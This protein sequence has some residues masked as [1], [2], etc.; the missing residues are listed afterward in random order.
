MS[1]LLASAV[2]F[3]LAAEDGAKKVFSDG[4][5][6]AEWAW[7]IPVVPMVAAF[8]IVLFGK[9]SP[10]KGWGMAWGILT[11]LFG[12]FAI[13]S[14]LTAFS[15]K[16]SVMPAPFLVRAQREAGLPAPGLCDRSDARRARRRAE[17]FDR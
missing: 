3:L 16:P 9:R 11:I 12:L 6:L 2:P 10:L 7:L 17:P 15:T 13:G 4:G 5:A 1:S 14:P 8:A